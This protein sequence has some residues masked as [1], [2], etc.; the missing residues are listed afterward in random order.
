MN[1][2]LLLIM[3]FSSM[4]LIWCSA[5]F[6]TK[7]YQN[8]DPVF[9]ENSSNYDELSYDELN[10]LE[11]ILDEKLSCNWWYE[12]EKTFISYAILDRIIIDEDIIY[13]LIVSGWW[14]Y[15]DK[16]WNLS[17]SCGFG[18]LPIVVK[19]KQTE[20]GFSF[21]SYKEAES[22]SEHFPSVKKMFSELAFK[23]WEDESFVYNTQET[24]L[25]KAEKYFWI[26]YWTGGTFDCSF[27]DKNWYKSWYT[28]D[29]KDGEV[30]WYEIFWNIKNSQNKY[31]IFRSDWSFENYNSWDAGTGVWIFWQD[32]NT[33]LVDAYPDHTYD[34]YIVQYLADN[35]FHLTREIMHK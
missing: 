4:L 19:I 14:I 13:N 25:Q 16:R 8:T 29:S 10:F 26:I 22:W 11:D 1:K 12:K 34:R 20:F 2:L 31:I 6:W 30:E 18:W 35:E 7:F 24:P 23:K 15:I 21:V 27:C 17:S 3:F 9:F 33:I 32:E 28:L 5:N